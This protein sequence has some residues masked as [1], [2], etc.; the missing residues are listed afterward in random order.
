MKRAKVRI[1]GNFRRSR[2]A[3]CENGH[4]QL[5]ALVAVAS[6]GECARGVVPR[7]GPLRR[8]HLLLHPQRNIRSEQCR[9][10]FDAAAQRLCRARAVTDCGQRSRAP[11][12][13]VCRAHLRTQIPRRHTERSAVAL[14]QGARVESQ[15]SLSTRSV[16]R[17]VQACAVRVG[18]ARSGRNVS[19]GWHRD[20]RGRRRRASHDTRVRVVSRPLGRGAQD[21]AEEVAVGRQWHHLQGDG[22]GRLGRGLAQQLLRLGRRHQRR[23]VPQGLRADAA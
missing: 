14:F 5:S 21:V 1:H 19:R 3:F 2:T 8:R 12:P 11:E 17:L 20:M 4:E 15:C 13:R 6:E 9:V 7:L 22:V 16:L 18:R 10:A 23:G